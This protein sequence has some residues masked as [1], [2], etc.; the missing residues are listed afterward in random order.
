MKESRRTFQVSDLNRAQRELFISTRVGLKWIECTPPFEYI[1]GINSN[2]LQFHLGRRF[3]NPILISDSPI[4]VTAT[5]LSML[6]LFPF[7][8]L[9]Y[10]KRPR[11][12]VTMWVSVCVCVCVCV[13]V[14]EL[15]RIYWSLVNY[16]SLATG[17]ISVHPFMPARWNFITGHD[18]NQ[19]ISL[20][21]CTHSLE[22]RYKFNLLNWW[23]P[24]TAWKQAL[25]PPAHPPAYPPVYL[26]TR[27]PSRMQLLYLERFQFQLLGEYTQ[28][29]P[30]SAAS[31]SKSQRTGENLIGR[32]KWTEEPQT[33]TVSIERSREWEI[34]HSPNEGT[35][36]RNAGESDSVH[37]Q[38]RSRMAKNG[39]EWPRMAKNGQ[40]WPRK[41]YDLNGSQVDGGSR[42]ESIVAVV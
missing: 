29:L 17:Y 31:D 7:S 35:W 24:L 1:N 25:P 15:P 26:S 9:L 20:I 36:K 10:G 38:E 13:H 4:K 40:K 16:S 30:S 39:Q 12:C 11:V 6:F 41:W 37:R 18:G 42:N 27:L 19:C 2:R 14:H 32:L 33:V 5:D 21:E 8:F 23:P 22:S 28:P 3:V 34:H